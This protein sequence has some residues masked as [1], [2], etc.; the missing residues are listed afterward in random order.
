[1]T[2]LQEAAAALDKLTGFEFHSRSTLTEVRVL[3]ELEKGS[4]ARQAA[5]KLGIDTSVAVRI[6]AKHGWQ[7]KVGRPRCL[8]S[9]G[10]TQP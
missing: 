1:M 6:A 3:A 4:N 8:K 5:R 10:A 2:A 9:S 7:G